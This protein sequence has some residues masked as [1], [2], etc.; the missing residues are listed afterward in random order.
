MV[1]DRLGIHTVPIHL[2]ATENDQKV[3]YLCEKS[4]RLGIK[5]HLGVDKI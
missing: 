4:K 3:Y 5:D 1:Q 2:Y